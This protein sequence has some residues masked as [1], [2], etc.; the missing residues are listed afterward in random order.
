MFLTRFGAG[1]RVGGTGDAT[2]TD[3]PYGK[4]SGLLQAV[5]VLKEIPEIAI[6]RLSQSDVVRHALEQTEVKAYEA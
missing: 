1:S 6:V 5:E 3:L 2:Q 4:Q